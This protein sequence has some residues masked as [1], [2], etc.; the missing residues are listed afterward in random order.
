MKHI[1]ANVQALKSSSTLRITEKAKAMKANGEDVIVLAAGEPDFGTPLSIREDAKKAI[2]NNF[3]GYTAV[4]G[5]KDLR[6]SFAKKIKERHNIEYGADQ[7]VVASGAKQALF[8]AI[9]SIVEPG[10][11]VLVIAP[12]WVSY[13]EMIHLCGAKPVIVDTS[14]N[15]FLPSVYLLDKYLTDKT[16][17][18]LLNT[19]NNPTGVVY[20]ESLLREIGE[21]IIKNDLYC[22]EDEIYEKLIYDGLHHFSISSMDGMY[23][24]TVLINGVSKSYAMTGWR[25]G[26]SASPPDIAN[27]IK[28]IQSHTTSCASSI[29]QKAALSAL[30]L[31][32]KEIDTMVAEF[33]ERR[34]YLINRFEKLAGISYVMPKGAF[35][36]FFTFDRGLNNEYD[37]IKIAE[38]LLDKVGVAVIPGNGFGNDR[39]LRISYA[40][41]MADLEEAVNRIES[42]L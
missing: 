2:D 17:L 39:Y 25:I 34:K 12:Y 14:K 18:V 28:K 13:P 41:S 11:E 7:I 35:Y 29:S 20:E 27:S 30:T 31:S 42:L 40:A 4:T 8:N 24:R 5:I 9:W 33:D 15:N 1:N 16:K 38:Y 22:I 23:D 36:L 6:E 21:F 32:D 26:Y 3:T 19:P 37:A 10:D